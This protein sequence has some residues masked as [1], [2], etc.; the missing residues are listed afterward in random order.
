MRRPIAKAAHI[1]WMRFYHLVMFVFLAIALYMMGISHAHATAQT[2]CMM[3][4]LAQSVYGR[5]LATLAIMAIGIGAMVGKVSWGMAIMVAVGVA[6]LFGASYLA[7]QLGARDVAG[8]SGGAS[9]CTDFH[10]N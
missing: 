3:A 10:V 8:L 5:G 7:G 1:D 4:A 6:V 2:L 9:G